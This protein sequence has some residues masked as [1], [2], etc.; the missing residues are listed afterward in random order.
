M[1]PMHTPLYR[2]IAAGF[3][4]LAAVLACSKK[5]AKAKWHTLFNL[6]TD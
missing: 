1:Q 3:L 6:P 5:F 2:C 4:T